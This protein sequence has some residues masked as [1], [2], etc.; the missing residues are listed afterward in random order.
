M[1]PP[2]SSPEAVARW[3][4]EQRWFARPVSEPGAD[5][6]DEPAVPFDVS[7]SEPLPLSDAPRVGLV[8]ATTADGHRYQLLLPTGGKPRRAGPTAGCRS[9]TRAIPRGPS[10]AIRV[11]ITVI[12]GPMMVREKVENM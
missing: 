8:L 1:T 3:L 11:K 12:T 10:N 6:S 7:L 4:T 2:Q 9:S 5:G